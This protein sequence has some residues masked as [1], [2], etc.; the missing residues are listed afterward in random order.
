[1]AF[2]SA[3]FILPEDTIVVLSTCDFI[4]EKSCSV[5]FHKQV[6]YSKIVHDDFA[7]KLALKRGRP[8]V[9][10]IIYIVN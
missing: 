8:Q 10:G 2:L 1:M 3:K 7:A 5:I 9:Y 4:T 6:S